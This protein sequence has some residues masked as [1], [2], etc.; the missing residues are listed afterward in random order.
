M[1]VPEGL[2]VEVN[3]SVRIGQIN[4]LGLEGAGNTFQLG[5]SN[6]L[7]HEAEGPNP[8]VINA[9]TNIGEVQVIRK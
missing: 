8:L 1:I 6:N 3:A 5:R 2:D 7:V 9:T 4:A